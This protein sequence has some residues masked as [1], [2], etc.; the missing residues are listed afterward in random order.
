MRR[1]NR[2]VAVTG[3]VLLA[4]TFVPWWW[5]LRVSGGD[6]RGVSLWGGPSGWAGA[7]LLALAGCWLGLGGAGRAGRIAA[8]GL[9]FAGGLV[10][11]IDT[12]RWPAAT[13]RRIADYSSESA[14]QTFGRQHSIRPG[15]FLGI[16]L[17]A[18]LT[19][20]L[21][22]AQ[23]ESRHDDDTPFAFHRPGRLT[24]LLAAVTLALLTVSFRPWSHPVTGWFSY[25]PL[26]AQ[27]AVPALDATAWQSSSVL[28]L[29]VLLAIAG[30]LAPRALPSRQTRIAIPPAL[31]AAALVLGAWRRFHGSDQAFIHSGEIVAGRPATGWA[32]AGLALLTALLVLVVL[33]SLRERKTPL[34]P[35]L[36]V[37]PS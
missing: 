1:T 37:E 35:A 21:R 11:L 8:W 15:V 18:V 28:A 5:Q 23:R 33:R 16:A 30:V 19:L 34:P 3:I 14:A 6:G 4:S 27:S 24:L 17:I 2:L 7:I 36:L 12:L 29:G 22:R 10:L 32:D 31:A 25:T 26:T 13:P 9:P 20:L